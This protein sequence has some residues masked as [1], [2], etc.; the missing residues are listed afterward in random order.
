MTANDLLSK[1]KD[2]LIVTFNDDDELILSFIAAAIQYAE[3]YQHVEEGYYQEHEPSE[4]TK[5]GI[6]MLSSFF[7]ESRDGGT[8]GYFSNSSA[9][10]E[11]TFKTVHTLFRLD[12]NWKV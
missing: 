3:S 12:R 6:I 4:V 9:A 2:N 5:Q 7:Y 8:A 10:A 11:Q 1:V